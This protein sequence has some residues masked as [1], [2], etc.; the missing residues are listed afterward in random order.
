VTSRGLLRRVLALYTGEQ[1]GRIRF[2]YLAKGKPFLSDVPG[3]ATVGFSV[4][5]T[6]E[7]T[8]LAIASTPEIGI[9]GDGSAPTSSV[10]A[11]G[12]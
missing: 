11:A 7:L 6:D 10:D 5:H 12:R 3:A 2:G 1:P 4:A 8:L 9:D